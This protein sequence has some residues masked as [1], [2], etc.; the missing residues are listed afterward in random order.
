MSQKRRAVHGGES[1][2]CTL[3]AANGRAPIDAHGRILAINPD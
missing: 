3:Q 1:A 2:A